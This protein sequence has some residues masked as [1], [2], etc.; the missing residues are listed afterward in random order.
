MFEY[1]IEEL[2][3]LKKSTDILRELED[4][5]VQPLTGTLLDYLVF[6]IQAYKKRANG[7]N[8]NQVFEKHLDSLCGCMGPM[9]GEPFCNCAMNRLRY[10]YRYDVAIALVNS[11]DFEPY[12]DEGAA[13]IQE[14]KDLKIELEETKNENRHL[15]ELI[16]EHLMKDRACFE[17]PSSSVEY[18]NSHS[19]D[20]FDYDEY[21]SLVLSDMGR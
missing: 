7:F 1:T 15:Q 19:R 6:R 4:L 9:N 11:R 13:R 3:A 2:Y 12:T 8:T 20:N 17:E 5:N 10:E 18:M 16:L 14:E 21:N